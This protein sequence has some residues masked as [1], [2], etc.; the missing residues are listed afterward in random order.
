MGISIFSFGFFPIAPLGDAAPQLS[1][2]IKD[3]DVVEL[4]ASEP[5]APVAGPAGCRLVRGRHD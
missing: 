3:Q 2:D 4:M 1:D 5:P